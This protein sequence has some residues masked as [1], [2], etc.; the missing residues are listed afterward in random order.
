MET[1]ALI[2]YRNV[3]TDGGIFLEALKSST[4]IVSALES[5]Y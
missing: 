2:T 5:K 4:G 1:V 3:I